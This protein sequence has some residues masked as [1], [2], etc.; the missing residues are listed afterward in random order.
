M[1]RLAGRE[2]PGNSAWI[3]A[4]SLLSRDAPGDFNQAMMELG[5]TVCVPGQP[6]CDVC[7]V[8]EFCGTRGDL[9]RRRAAVRKT[10]T[11]GYTLAVRGSSVLLV[12]RPRDAARMAQMWELP[13]CRVNGVRP[14]LRLRHSI[15][16]TDYDV[17]VYRSNKT[18]AAG[19]GAWVPL[20]SAGRL[21]LTGL[22][23]KIL[24]RVVI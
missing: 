5:A 4:E 23:R 6:R 19:G 14:L 8:R 11:V 2:L 21:P 24:N 3:A 1:Q 15:T 9:P 18:T 10:A 13:E 7:P 16:D 22:A 12:Q 20:A 17:R